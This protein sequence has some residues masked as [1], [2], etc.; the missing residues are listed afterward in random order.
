MRGDGML[1]ELLGLQKI[2]NKDAARRALKAIDESEGTT[3]LQLTPPI[4]V[5]L[6]TL[7]VCEAGPALLANPLWQL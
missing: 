2:V 6:S 5:L 7:T 4:A 1:P 3:W